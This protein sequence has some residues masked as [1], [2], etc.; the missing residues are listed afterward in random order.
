MN[1]VI[2]KISFGLILFFSGMPE[3][4]TQTSFSIEDERMYFPADGENSPRC[5]RT[6]FCFAATFIC[7]GDV[8]NTSTELCEGTVKIVRD[9]DFCNVVGI[10]GLASDSETYIGQTQIENV[11][12][13]SVP[14]APSETVAH[15]IEIC[16]DIISFSNP[17]F[18][19]LDILISNGAIIPFPVL[20]I[21][22]ELDDPSNGYFNFNPGDLIWPVRE[23]N[24]FFPFSS[25]FPVSPSQGLHITTF[26]VYVQNLFVI[27]ED[28]RFS[29]LLDPTD[30][31][32][33]VFTPDS[34]IIIQSG[35]TFE[36]KDWTLLPCESNWEGIIVE[37]GATLIMDNCTIEGAN[38]AITVEEGGTLVLKKTTIRNSIYGVQLEGD[39]IVTIDDS[40][41]LGLQIGVTFDNSTSEILSFEN[42]T[43][44]ANKWGINIQNGSNFN[45]TPNEE[46]PNIFDK[47]LIGMNI[48]GSSN[49]GIGLN[50]FKSN[51]TSI[52]IEGSSNIEL[53]DN[54]IGSKMN[55]G[56]GVHVKNSSFSAISNEIGIGDDIGSIGLLGESILFYFVDD[57]DIEAVRKGIELIASYGVVTNNRIGQNYN[58]YIGIDQ[59][60]GIDNINNNEI[61]STVYSILSNSS[62]NSIIQ[63]NLL[64]GARN[65]VF[66][67]GGSNGLIV[68]DNVVD[69][70]QSGLRTDNANFNTFECNEVY[71]N[72]SIWINFG[73]EFQD[74]IGNDLYGNHE[75]I[76]I[77]SI[78]GIQDHNGNVFNGESLTAMGLSDFEIVGSVFNV[79]EGNADLIPDDVSHNDLINIE[80][81]GELK[82]CSGT[83]GPNAANLLTSD[84][85]CQ[86]LKYLISIQDKAPKETRNTIVRLLRYYLLNSNAI[87]SECLDKYLVTEVDDNVRFQLNKEIELR[88]AI[89]NPSS[90]N[91]RTS[92]FSQIVT[93][94]MSSM[95]S[96]NQSNDEAFETWADVY[97]LLL[98]RL[99][100]QSFKDTD[101]ALLKSHAR[102]C[103][104]E[105]GDPVHWARSLLSNYSDEDFYK[106]DDCKDTSEKRSNSEIDKNEIE[107]LVFPNPAS[108]FIKLKFQNPIS[109]S[110]T[111]R[112]IKGSTIIKEVIKSEPEYLLQINGIIDGLYLIEVLT[113]DG[114]EFSKKFIKN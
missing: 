90:T 67:V 59:M 3:S 10:S 97:D 13:Y 23:T 54:N 77:E 25:T 69:S 27:D 78:L 85:I 11:Y 99:S 100:N 39:C 82:S 104:F 86:Y 30:P 111:L 80:S 88:N 84:F 15:E 74:L 17:R 73:S 34:E 106:F 109:G 37:S 28:T 21:Y 1:N 43:F 42:N 113:N 57:N 58:T 94:Q 93:S 56:I 32:E 87:A 89:K 12:N 114:Q 110:I 31:K 52:K 33:I 7:E 98:K 14:V 108:D 49:I 26:P 18:D 61:K 66:L 45:I 9:R 38:I 92:N 2:I 62:F 105:Y 101:L 63:N 5:D 46:L 48:N 70:D 102:K 91:A 68:S 107:L 96:K 103:A 8:E 19:F 51:D 41:F 64:E 6:E 22:W 29:T 35:N 79:E 24:N 81:T 55:S 83:P 53:I 76:L 47:C 40:N 95:D 71:S 4:I 75:D 60:F 36:L 72:N 16:Y 44:D 20:D 50:D 112:D 65:S